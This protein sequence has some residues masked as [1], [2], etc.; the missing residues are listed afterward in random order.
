MAKDE[1]KQGP[2]KPK[3]DIAVSWGLSYPNGIGGIKPIKNA[4][5]Q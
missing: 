4:G 5:K 3:Y 2:P 1:K